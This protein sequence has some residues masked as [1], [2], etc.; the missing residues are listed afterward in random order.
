MDNFV[1][2]FFTYLSLILI[3][4]KLWGY[5]HWPWWVVV[6][7]FMALVLFGFAGSLYERYR[8]RDD[9]PEALKRI[10]KMLDEA[11]RK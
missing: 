1:I 10:Q 8:K 3:A 6:M 4:S 11:D 7:P 9:R 5:I 2:A